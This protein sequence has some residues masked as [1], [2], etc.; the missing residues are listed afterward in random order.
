[1]SE[2]ASAVLTADEAAAIIVRISPRSVRRLTERGILHP[3]A[4][5]GRIVR[6]A[7]DDVHSLISGTPAGTEYRSHWGTWHKNRTKEGAL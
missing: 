2:T 5:G 7:A 6:D 4:R 3:L 1:M